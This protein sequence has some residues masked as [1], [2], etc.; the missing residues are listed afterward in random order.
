[1]TAFDEVLEALPSIRIQDPE[2]SEK[3]YIEIVRG[4]GIFSSK[5]L[6]CSISFFSEHNQIM[7]ECFTD[8]EKD[9]RRLLDEFYGRDG[10]AKVRTAHLIDDW[11]CTALALCKEGFTL[12]DVL[13]QAGLSKEMTKYVEGIPAFVEQLALFF[14]TEAIFDVAMMIS[15]YPL[16]L[17]FLLNEKENLSEL[18]KNCQ[19]EV[20]D[21]VDRAVESACESQKGIIVEEL[22]KC[23]LLK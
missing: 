19:K 11:F 20:R 10:A 8:L 16:R 12:A 17:I 7:V 14:P 13:S 15:D 21:Y 2:L 9:A 3:D 22:A 18:L 6:A 23:G 1:M 4:R 5:R